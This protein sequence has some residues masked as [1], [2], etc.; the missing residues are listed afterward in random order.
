MAHAQTAPRPPVAALP[1]SRVASASRAL[2][3]RWSVGRHP[4][5]AGREPRRRPACRGRRAQTLLT[6][7]IDGGATAGVVRGAPAGAGGLRRLPPSFCSGRA[8]SVRHLLPRTVGSAQ[9]THTPLA[10]PRTAR[11][12]DARGVHNGHTTG[13][14]HRARPRPRTVAA[15]APTTQQRA[16]DAG[17]QR[18]QEGQAGARRRHR[19]GGQ[20]R[21]VDPTQGGSVEVGSQ[22]GRKEAIRPIIRFRLVHVI[23]YIR[24]GDA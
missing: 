7:G 24:F 13:N 8:V 23:L 21:L 12:R 4:Q 2:L 1:L 3:T 18:E 16:R 10:R 20:A 9:R 17:T 11:H 15:A 6:V 22:A 5:V 14:I 19:E